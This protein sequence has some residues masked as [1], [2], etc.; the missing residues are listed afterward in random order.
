MK[1]EGAS[2]RKIAE[3]LNQREIE[4]ARGGTWAATQVWDILL[5]PEDTE[6]LA[7]I[8]AMVA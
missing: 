2:Q 6:L 3:A 7:Q 4:T 8:R 1:A 5:R